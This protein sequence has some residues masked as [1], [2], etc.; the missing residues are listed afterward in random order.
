MLLIRRLADNANKGPQPSMDPTKP[1]RKM[2]K[3]A[4][5]HAVATIAAAA[6]TIALFS[7]VVS[8]ADDDKAALLAAKTGPTTIAANADEAA[9]L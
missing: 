5:K 8:L 1:E 2:F 3:N 7:A 6:T 4:L 9:K